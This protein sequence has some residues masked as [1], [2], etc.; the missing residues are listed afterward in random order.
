MV[1][2]TNLQTFVNRQAEQVRTLGLETALRQ[3]KQIASE[4]IRRVIARTPVDSGDAAGNW[5]IIIGAEADPPFVRGRTAEAAL[6]DAVS[7]INTLRTFIKINIAN[8]A[9][10]ILV[11]ENG[12]FRPPSP[13]P[14]KDP[15]PGRKGRILV[16]GGFSLQAPSG[17]VK[18]TIAELGIG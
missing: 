11:L 5:Y 18:V 13:G 12:G 10:H 16:S 15:R 17:M 4:A 14:S 8:G 6:V 3:M 2:R 9:P 1:L 7:R